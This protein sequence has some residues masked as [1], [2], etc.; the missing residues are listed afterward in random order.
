MYTW[1]WS[2]FLEESPTGD[3]Y[4]ETLFIGLKFTL[5]VAGFGWLIA[6]VLGTIIGTLRTTE[7]KWVVMLANG[8][9]ELF[10]NIPL[11]VQMFIWFYVVPDFFLPA[12]M[13]IWYK[14]ELP[15][16][17]DIPL[18]TAILALG[19]FTSARIAVQVT[20]GIN[21]LPRGQRYA[22]LAMGF[23]PIQTYRYVLLP[24][25][26]R[27]ITPALVNEVAAIIKNS[28]VA[29]VISVVE[30]TAAAYSMN[31]FT[32]KTFEALTGATTIYI[33]VSIFA[34]FFAHFLEKFVR[35]PGY[36]TSGSTSSGGH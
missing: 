32:F 8:Y 29:L 9:V 25:A 34:L 18:L 22:G 27:I 30:L 12:G 13:Q 3:T 14:Q 15:R 6:I 7:K 10:R 33:L 19:F 17:I 11:L 35:V 24:M 5:I 21:A 4:L 2:I 23:T 26:F 31:E 36:V 20:A 1:D 16:H 28:S